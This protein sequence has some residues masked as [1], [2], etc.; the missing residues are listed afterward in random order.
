M[1]GGSTIVH[2]MVSSRPAE[3]YKVEMPKIQRE[4]Q[5]NDPI[6]LSDFT[7]LSWVFFDF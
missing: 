3:K 5:N 4:V 1:R 7:P 2:L 6:S